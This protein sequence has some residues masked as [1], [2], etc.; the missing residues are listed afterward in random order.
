MLLSLQLSRCDTGQTSSNRSC[1][2]LRARM[3]RGVNQLNV[4]KEKNPALST[5]WHHLRSNTQVS[6]PACLLGTYQVL[7]IIA[8]QICVCVCGGGLTCHPLHLCSALH[9][10]LCPPPALHSGSQ[11]I[12]PP[13]KPDHTHTD[14]HSTHLLNFYCL[15]V[16]S[17]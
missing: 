11:L 7:T 17:I 15:Y 5:G 4:M 3:A 1:F 14:T 13:V 8:K 2:F 16:F 12:C 10:W 6:A 9:H